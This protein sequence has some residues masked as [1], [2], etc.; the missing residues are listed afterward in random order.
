MKEFSL[1][2]Y[3]DPYNPYDDTSSLSD[4]DKN[5]FDVNKKSKILKKGLDESEEILTQLNSI[6]NYMEDDRYMS[7]FVFG[8]GE[9]SEERDQIKRMISKIRDELMK[10]YKLKS[11]VKSKNHFSKK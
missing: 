6:L 2:K 8:T 9:K 11:K 7:N 3:L 4:N 5:F 10:L 1:L